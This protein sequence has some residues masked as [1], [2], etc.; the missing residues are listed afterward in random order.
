MRSRSRHLR[1]Q[2]RSSPWTSIRSPAI[3]RHHGRQRGDAENVIDEK[4]LGD[5]EKALMR[6]KAHREDLLGMGDLQGLAW[7]MYR[8]LVRDEK[9]LACRTIEALRKTVKTV[10]GKAGPM[11]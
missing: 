1:R 3:E 8:I 6:Q 2:V 10:M 5:I 9:Q 4:T 11:E 7:V